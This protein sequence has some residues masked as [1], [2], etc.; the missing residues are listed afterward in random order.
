[1]K[2]SPWPE[3]FSRV[4][5]LLGLLASAASCKEEDTH[6]VTAIAQFTESIVALPENESEKTISLWLHQPAPA[7]GQIVVKATTFVPT[8]FSTSPVAE[9]GQIKLSVLKGETKV[10]FKLTPT[11]NQDIDGPK[12]IKF[13]ILSVS[14]GL[15]YGFSNEMVVTVTDDEGP[16]DAAFETSAMHVREN[17]A[18]AASVEIALAGNTAADGI[19]VVKL[20]SSSRYGIDYATEPAP[21][22]G[23]IFLPVAKGASSAVIKLYGVDDKAFKADRNINFTIVD[24]SGGVAVGHKDSFW[25]TIT[26]DDGHQISAIESIRSMYSGS[27]VIVQ[28]DTYIEG[29]V[30]SI[31]NVSAG[32]VVVEDA[33]GALPIQFSSANSL[34]RGD[35]VLVNIKQGRLHELHGVLEVGQVSSGFEK[36]GEE[37]VRINKLTLDELLD[38]GDRFESQTI[39][40]IGVL[41]SQADGAITYRGDRSISDGDNSMIV[42]TGTSAH[43]GDD[44]VPN[45]LVNV[46]GIF[47]N[48]DGLYI[49]YPQDSKDIKKQQFQLRRD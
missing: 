41:F 26:D 25:A 35:L 3:H 28:E 16:V 36:L 8:C 27:D 29:I 18:T 4:F 42:R 24:A 14:S 1:M 47:T 45:G 32:R 23:R 37:S 20:E 30:T 21:A 11:D 9:T 15:S 38:S 19:L 22:N 33:S 13:A 40:L 5:V 12:I 44:I 17:D 46:T 39:Q 43:F 31:D 48:S 49:I 2:F 7:D 34:T 6:G 10:S